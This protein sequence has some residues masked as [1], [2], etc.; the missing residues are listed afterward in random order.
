MLSRSI[1]TQHWFFIFLIA[2]GIADQIGISSIACC[3]VVASIVSGIA[4]TVQD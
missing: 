3:L 1:K 4:Y 2:T